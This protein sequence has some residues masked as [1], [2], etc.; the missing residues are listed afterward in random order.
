MLFRSPV[1]PDAININ[2][3]LSKGQLLTAIKAVDGAGSGLDADLLDGKDSTQFVRS[4]VQTL[5]NADL[6]MQGHNLI[7]NNGNY[8]AKMILQS[9]NNF[10]FYTPFHTLS[11]G[12]SV[13][14]S[15]L[16][17]R[18]K[19]WTSGNDGAGSG[20]DADLVRGLPADFTSSKATNGYQKL[21]SGL[22]IQWGHINTGTSNS[23]ISVTFPIAFPSLCSS[24]YISADTVGGSDGRVP[25]TR[26][27]S[28]SGFTIT[29]DSFDSTARDSN[30]TEFWLAIGY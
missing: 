18:Q 3:P 25:R 20:L 16:L 21:P 7:F 15:V 17:D 2:E 12:T 4:D 14:E 13:G 26:N 1:I 23:N 22:I 10:M 19:I 9:D 5:M 8:S 28:V 6:N 24:V 30:Y 27:K 29:H 11:F